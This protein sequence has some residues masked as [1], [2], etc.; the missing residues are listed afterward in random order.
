M[1]TPR[2]KRNSSKV[3]LVISFVFHA[4]I[5]GALIFFAAREGLLGKQLKKI[6]VVMVPKEKP[7]EKPKEPEKQPEPPKTETP[8]TEPPKV[9]TVPKTEPPPVTRATA[10]P[11]VAP[12]A[13]PPPTAA[14]SF[15]FADGA[16]AVQSTS[17]AVG[18]YKNFVE[19]SIRSKWVRPE[20]IDDLSYVA[21]V[22]VVIEPSGA[23]APGEWKR[24]SGNK[25]WDES[26]RRALSQTTKVSRTPPKNFPAKVI[27]RF[28][29]T[30]EQ[31]T[32]PLESL[33]R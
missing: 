30:T 26:V 12:A 2:R 7:P 6:A 25:A 29:V 10:P 3:N 17:D 11:P 14:P 15:D 22:E 27:L 33:L 31:S 13:A 18:L 8:K 9:A 16:K 5:I 21:E 4:V 32:E 19:F 24:T 28:N 23:I 20:G 1:A